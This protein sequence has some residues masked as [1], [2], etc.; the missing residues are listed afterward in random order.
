M[1]PTISLDGPFRD[2]LKSP[3]DVPLIEFYRREMEPILV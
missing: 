3:L 1:N 2:E